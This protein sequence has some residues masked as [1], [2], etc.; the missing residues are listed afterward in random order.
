VS[1]LRVDY[2]ASR[3]VLEVEGIRFSGEFFR[4]FALPNP[5]ALY[6]IQRDGD[7][8]VVIRRYLVGKG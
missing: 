1:A 7:G 6:S 4:T 8:H 3:D 2:D 5:E